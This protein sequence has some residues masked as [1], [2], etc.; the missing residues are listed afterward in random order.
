MNRAGESAFE[1]LRLMAV[2]AHPDDE[3]LGTGGTLARYAGEGV[4][5]YLIT[6]TRGERGRNGESRSSS[7]AQLGAL[8]EAELREA[9]KVLGVSE[10]HLLDYP[11]GAL[12]QVDPR[13][14]AARIAAHIR[15]GRP[16]VVITFGPEGAY[17]HPDHIAIS[18]FTTA[19]VMYAAGSAHDTHTL[20]RDDPPHQVSKLYY[21]AWTKG[22][23]DAY[24][25]ALKK[26]TAKVDGVE[27][28]VTPWPDWA[29]TTAIDTSSYSPVV[30]R[31]VSCH[32]TQMSIYRN[33]EHLPADHHR[34][35][36]GSQEFYRVFSLVNGGREL[37][38]DLFM[39]LRSHTLQELTT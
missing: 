34:A 13:E 11:D 10:V 27:R 3:S 7:P 20:D 26:L 8:R 30:W 5:T 24:Q 22:K 29:V 6:A 39:G 19:A 32:Q 33:L 23:W 38:T 37:E 21:I 9:A 36:W 2:L 14:A 17:G 12:D 35:L 16:H 28:Q 31:A 25:A 1:D 18:Q 15:R 4:R